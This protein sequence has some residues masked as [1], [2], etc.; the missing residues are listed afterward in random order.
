M[1]DML[2]RLKAFYDSPEG[3]KHLEEYVKKINDEQA[4]LNSQ[5]ERFWSKYQNRLTEI[6]EKVLAKYGNHKYRDLWYNRGIEPPEPL[7]FFLYDVAKQYGREFTEDEYRAKAEAG[8]LMFTADIW[9]LGEWEFELI[10][11]QGSA[12]LVNKHNAK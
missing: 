2:D 1:S 11:G 6:V 5:I 3:Q 9:V 8:R 7:L 12:I 10:I 4:I